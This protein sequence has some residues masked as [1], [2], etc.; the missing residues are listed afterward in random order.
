M[1]LAIAKLKVFFQP[2]SEDG[3]CRRC[4]SLPQSA[5]PGIAP[6]PVCDACAALPDAIAYADTH[7][8]N[9][10]AVWVGNIRARSDARIRAREQELAQQE[11]ARVNELRGKVVQAFL[12][13]NAEEAKRLEE[14]ARRLHAGAITFSEDLKDDPAV[15]ANVGQVLGHRHLVPAVPVNTRA[16]TGETPK[17]GSK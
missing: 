2:K 3:R 13:G 16:A 12:S 9:E 4:R 15:W 5:H 1:F 8:P 11:F 17:A 14:T 10:L 7:F 6:V